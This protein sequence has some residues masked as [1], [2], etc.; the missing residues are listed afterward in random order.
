MS[1][2][3]KISAIAV[4]VVVLLFV[5]VVV[6]V[7]LLFDPNDY[8]DDIT[9][10]VQN[11]TG[12]QLTLDGDL[13]LALFPTIRIAVGA[14]SLSNAPGF[15]AEPMARIGSASLSLALLPLLARRVEIS[16]ARL[17]GLELNLARNR[18][19]ANNW[20]DLGG[21]AGPAGDA[22]AAAG[23]GGALGSR[24]RRR[25]PRDR[26]CAHRLERRLDRQPLGAHGVRSDGRRFRRRRALSAAYGVRACGRRRR[27]PGRRR[28]ASNAR[29][30]RQRVPARGARRHGRRQR[31][32][33][34]RRAEP[35]RA[36]ASSRWSP[37]SP[38]RRSS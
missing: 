35:S 2:V 14:A 18:G 22:P 15:G 24:S 20:Q 21:S 38:T 34:A 33:L 4:G 30:G 11:A 27:R 9:A 32:R 3:L 12:R 28:H 7:G 29:V 37:I 25:R 8:K 6:A 13:E 1:R 26:R 5:V 36:R 10:A 19:G 31:R 16:Q 23:G 17:E